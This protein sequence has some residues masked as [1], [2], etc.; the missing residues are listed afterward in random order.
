[1][2]KREKQAVEAKVAWCDSYLFYQKYHGCPVEPGMWKAATA[3]FADILQKTKINTGAAVE[4]HRQKDQ[5]NVSPK[6]IEAI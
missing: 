4:N 5:R 2:T 3:D 6:W 1:M